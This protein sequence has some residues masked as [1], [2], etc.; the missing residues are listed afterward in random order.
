MIPKS[1][2]RFSDKIMRK[3]VKARL[4]IRTMTITTAA[5]LALGASAAAQTS[6]QARPVLKA[7][8][9]VTGDFVRIGDLVEHAGI[10]ANVP[11][12][13]APDLGFTGTVPADAIVEAVRTH[14][15]VGLDTG[16]VSQVVVIR[17]SRTIPAKDIEDCVAQALSA[18]FGL[19]EAKNIGVN[20][21]REMRTIQVEPTAKGEP[22]IARIAYD[23]RSGKF[24]ATLELPTGAANRGMLR[25]SGRALATAEVVTIL[26]PVERGGILRETDVSVERRPRAEIGRD[27][28]TDR[29]QAIGFAARN[30]LQMGQPLRG[31]DVMKP[32]MVQRN[33]TVTLT[34]EMPGITLTVRGKAAEGG[35]EGD[36]I[37]VLNE[38][39]KRTVQ[40]VVVGPGRVIVSTSSPRLAANILPTQ[41][42]ASDRAR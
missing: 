5:L 17:A 4:M 9:I 40:G 33:E 30:A 29:Q 14:A 12:F 25:L 39:S 34:Y 2:N 27:F 20:F 15:L 16:G 28:I 13:R 32:E 38:Q 22:R 8:A 11:I 21:E 7:E 23:P 42:A 18:K 6:D 24:D 3:Y 36:V 10:I 19:G 35:A 1:G 37:S 26:R 41:T 31:A